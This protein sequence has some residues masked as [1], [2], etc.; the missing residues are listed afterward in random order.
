V[1]TF[2][3]RVRPVRKA[4]RRAAGELGVRVALEG[5]RITDADGNELR[6]KPS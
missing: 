5:A 3:D 6:S 1:S 4:L 2:D